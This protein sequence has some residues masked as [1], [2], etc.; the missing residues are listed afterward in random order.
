[1]D[2]SLDINVLDEQF[3][4]MSRFGLIIDKV[5]NSRNSSE[6]KMVGSMSREKADD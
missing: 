2:V 4:S 1:M 3:D 6:D 5:C